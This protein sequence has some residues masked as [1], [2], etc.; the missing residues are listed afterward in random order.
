MDLESMHVDFLLQIVF[1]LF[2]L[3][4]VTLIL[5]ICVLQL[6]L[7]FKA[8]LEPKVLRLSNK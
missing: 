5:L 6:V 4:L 3:F 1:E 7:L 2:L 8:L